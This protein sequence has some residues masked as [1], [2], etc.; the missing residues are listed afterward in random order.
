M[1]YKMKEWE[2]RLCGDLSGDAVYAFGAPVVVETAHR[3]S[4][5]PLAERCVLPGRVHFC[6]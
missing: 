6:D 4:T 5:S 2:R 3:Q 1:L